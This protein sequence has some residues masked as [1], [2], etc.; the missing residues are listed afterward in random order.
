[1]FDSPEY[2]QSLSEDLF[3]EWLEKGRESRIPYA[4]LLVIW[5]EIEGKYRPVYVEQRNQIQ[6]YPRFGQS[7]ENQ[8]LVA[9]YDL[10]SESRVV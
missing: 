2:P 9:A 6:S 1:M 8:M 10:Y 5:D 7:P 3:E 4:Y